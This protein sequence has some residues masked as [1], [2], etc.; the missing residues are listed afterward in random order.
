M[1]VRLGRQQIP[2]SGSFFR[3]R[4]SGLFGPITGSAVLGDPVYPREDGTVTASLATI[5][6]PIGH[7][8]SVDGTTQYYI[9]FDGSSRPSS[10]NNVNITQAEA[11]PALLIDL[12]TSA[13][14]QAI[15][16]TEDAVD[17]TLPMVSITTD[18]AR[19][20][21]TAAGLTVTNAGDGYG[22]RIAQSGARNAISINVSGGN[23]SQAE[24]VTETAV[25]R[26]KAMFSWTRDAT[27]TG[28]VLQITQPGTGAAIDIVSGDI[29]L[30]LAQKLSL[31]AGTYI[32]SDITDRIKVFT[33]DT[34]IAYW[35][36]T[37]IYY[38]RHH[39]PITTAAYSLGNS[40]NKWLGLT[41]SGDAT[42]GG[43]VVVENSGS[44]PNPQLMASDINPATTG[45]TASEGSV[46][47]RYNAGAGEVWVK[48]GSADDAWAVVSTSSAGGG[49]WVDGTV[50][51]PGAKFTSDTD[52]GVWRPGDNEFAIAV[53]GQEPIRWSQSQSLFHSGSV[54][55]PAI[56]AAAWPSTG[57]TFLSDQMLISIDGVQSGYW[58]AGG[59]FGSTNHQPIGDSI[60]SLG[61]PTLKW[62][63]IRLSDAVECAGSGTFES[64]VRVGDGTVA[65]PGH[66]FIDDS[67]TG[68]FRAAEDIFAISA[69]GI[70]TSRWN[71]AGQQLLTTG[72]PDITEFGVCF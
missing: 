72:S 5:V 48:T 70:E 66:T 37:G 63:V 16:I 40:S 68:I 3:A 55:R 71:V 45:L 41:L 10:F 2:A 51:A 15:V 8:V 61:Q 1:L 20:G 50:G 65:A 69:G 33:N 53:G 19:T 23:N 14:A 7:V 27:A 18:G 56:A 43:N 60:Y 21:A 9:H 11:S 47:M 42:V 30:G 67:D 46:M 6:R 64:I 24:V 62:K 39:F 28:P 31:S 4:R 26:T 17:R 29:V 58:L 12:D 13:S 34:N 54:L 36:P 38:S 59:V 44:T 22:L 25:A 35:D 52:T 49:D 57:F 32:E